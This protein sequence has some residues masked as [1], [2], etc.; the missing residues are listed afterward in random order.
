MPLPNGPIDPKHNPLITTPFYQIWDGEG[1]NPPPPGTE[2]RIT[3][4]G[5]GRI[6][7]NNN[8]RITD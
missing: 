5:L 2:I 8:L 6:T 4:S 3:D 7:D 1:I